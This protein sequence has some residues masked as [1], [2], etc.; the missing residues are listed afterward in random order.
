MIIATDLEGILMPE[1]WEH[2]AIETGIEALKVTTRDEPDFVKLMEH[3]V[4]VLR[5]HDIKLPDLVAMAHQVEPFLATRAFLKWARTKGQIMIISDTFQEFA[6]HFIDVV[7]AYNLF[8]NRFQFAPDGTILGCNLRIRGKKERVTQSL[9]DIGFFVVGIG[10]SF[11]D[12]SLLKSC[13][14]PILYRTPS[15][16]TKQFPNAP[17]VTNLDDLKSTIEALPDEPNG[18][19][20][21]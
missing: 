14:F 2:I 20:S 1:I 5:E 17:R 8:A 7:G 6:D 18:N 13:S 21:A 10:D 16:V 19:G 15:E 3:R 9:K 12:I 11:N 4:S